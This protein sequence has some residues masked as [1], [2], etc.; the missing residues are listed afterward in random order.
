[1]NANHMS[2]DQGAKTGTAPSWTRIRQVVV[3]AR[4]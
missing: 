1:L 4:L 2:E 3:R